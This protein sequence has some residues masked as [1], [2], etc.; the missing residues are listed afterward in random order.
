MPRYSLIEY[1]KSYSK[2][3]GNLW[4]YYRDEPNSGAEGNINYFIKNSKSFD[5]KARTTG[6]L[7]GI[8]TEKEG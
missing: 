5:Y 7:E 2:I 3:T 6:R 1:S 4:S 8:I